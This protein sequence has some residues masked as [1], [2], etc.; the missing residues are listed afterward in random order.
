MSTPMKIKRL[1]GAIL[2]A[3][4]AIVLMSSCASLSSGRSVSA[5]D[6]AL[7]DLYDSWQAN[8]ALIED[9]NFVQAVVELDELRHFASGN[10]GESCSSRCKHECSG[11][12]VASCALNC[13]HGHGCYPSCCGCKDGTT[14][15]KDCG[16]TCASDGTFLLELGD[17]SFTYEYILAELG[18]LRS[19]I[20]LW[21]KSDDE[22]K[23]STAEA[24]NS[25]L[26]AVAK[27]LANINYDKE[28]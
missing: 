14:M 8:P 3:F 7:L 21:L 19:D 22:L 25:D 6:G 20:D 26:D 9:A 15:C 27:R 10:L 16:A 13:V 24:I 4:T 11:L 28:N 23:E 12:N 18:S 1:L 2:V 5:L 17:G